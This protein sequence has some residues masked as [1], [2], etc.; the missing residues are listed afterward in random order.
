MRTIALMVA[1]ACIAAPAY[2]D[3][4]SGRFTAKPALSTPSMESRATPATADEAITS[5]LPVVSSEGQLVGQVFEVIR[6]AN[7][8]V[9]RVLIDVRDGKHRAVPPANIRFED[10]E[11]KLSLSR[12][13]VIALPAVQP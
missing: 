6:S 2:A 13:Q 5:G 10:G 9:T 7:G 1:A 12:A 11:A 8:R 4:A 3:Q